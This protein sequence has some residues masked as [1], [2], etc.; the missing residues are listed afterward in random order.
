MGNLTK[1]ENYLKV[2]LEVELLISLKLP[3][4]QKVF[5]LVL[6]INVRISELTKEFE[7]SWP[8]AKDT[9]HVDCGKRQEKSLEMG[10]LN[11]SM[12]PKFFE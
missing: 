9:N 7:N 5:L 2:E 4:L 10:F 3:Q 8:R 1:L 6:I 11:F 12:Q